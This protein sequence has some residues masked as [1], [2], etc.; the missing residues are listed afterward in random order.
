M[1]ARCLEAALSW[2]AAGYHGDAAHHYQ[3]RNTLD[4]A[5]IVKVQHLKQ[6]I[7]ETKLVN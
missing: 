5:E 6:N 3:Q 7:T 1:V 2:I 4:S